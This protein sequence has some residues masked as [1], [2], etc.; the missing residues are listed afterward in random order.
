MIRIQP[1]LFFM[2][3]EPQVGHQTACTWLRVGSLVFM[4]VDDTTIPKRS[5]AQF[6]TV[7]SDRC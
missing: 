7:N 6:C 4:A 3:F 5:D 1:T 2:A